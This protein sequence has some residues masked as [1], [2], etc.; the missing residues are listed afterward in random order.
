MLC[1]T[2]AS[3]GEHHTIPLKEATGPFSVSFFDLELEHALSTFRDHQL[4]CKCCIQRLYMDTESRLCD[5]VL[6]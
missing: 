2:R 6:R 5:V 3:C 4:G 1:L